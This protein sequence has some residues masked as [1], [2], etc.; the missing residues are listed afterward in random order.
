M[1][2]GSAH[3][4]GVGNANMTLRHKIAI[5]SRAHIYLVTTPAAWSSLKTAKAAVAANPIPAR[6]TAVDS[7]TVSTTDGAAAYIIYSYNAEPGFLRKSKILDMRHAILVA[8]VAHG[9]LFTFGGGGASW[10]ES[11]IKSIGTKVDPLVLAKLLNRPTVRLERIASQNM[12]I[13]SDIVRDR[14]LEG[15]DIEGAIPPN[16][17]SRQIIRS[18]RV[19]FDAERLTASPFTGRIQEDKVKG[20]LDGYIRWASKIAKEL[21]KSRSAP[22]FL[23]YFAHPISV[24]KLPTGIVPNGVLVNLSWL[25]EGLANGDFSLRIAGAGN[26]SGWR[27]ISQRLAAKVA[28]RLAEIGVVSSSPG[29]GGTYDVAYAGLPLSI[30]VK[31]RPNKDSFTLFSAQMTKVRI[32]PTATPDETETLTE[33]LR[34][35]HSV[36]VTFSDVRY[37]YS[38]NYLFADQRIQS[39][40]KTIIAAIRSDV[41]LSACSAEKASN[42]GAAGPEFCRKSVFGAIEH[43]LS[44]GKALVCDD[45]GDE[46]ADFIEVDPGSHGNA[47]SISL[48]HAKF[49]SKTT[50]ASA[51]QE[52]IGQATKNLGKLS[53]TE[54]DLRNKT[55]VWAGNWKAPV[56]S[57]MPDVP[58]VRAGGNAAQAVAMY[59]AASAAPN[60]R[61]RVCLVTS[62]GS[63]AVLTKLLQNAAAGR[64]VKPHAAQLAWLLIGFI[65]SCRVVGAE[66]VIVCAP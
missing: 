45:M 25:H 21:G 59:Q 43:S 47:P 66:P 34:T 37:T 52:V 20:T 7:G 24:D 44:S 36:T 17:Q 54:E 12:S 15:A 55:S 41:S 5:G 46:W 30:S 64:K 31:L 63:A 4:G 61:K 35:E 19:Q 38:G 23:S 13:A 48:Y 42:L 11:N 33:R 49:G 50:S 9:Y 6:A 22:N 65:S 10:T 1:G 39:Q 62:F 56:G 60:V 57:G 26:P 14:V 16:D 28:K 2:G 40:V 27:E 3:W 51:F 58:R 18:L 29:P 32:V 8:T 53:V